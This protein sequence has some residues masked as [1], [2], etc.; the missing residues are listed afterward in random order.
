MI[1]RPPRG[2]DTLNNK[3]KTRKKAMASAIDFGLTRHLT[4]RGLVMK[5]QSS[6]R[7]GL[8]KPVL[9]GAVGVGEAEAVLSA[10]C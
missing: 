7:L 10:E 3:E 4:S 1:T 8:R 2:S 5:S 6:R 9:A